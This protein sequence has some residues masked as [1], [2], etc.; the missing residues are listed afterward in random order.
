MARIDLWFLLLAT[1]CLVGGVSMGIGMGISQD[2]SLTPVHVH[3]NLVGWASL[4]L[5]GLTYR[6]WPEMRE[7][8]WAKAH[9][10][11]SA[12]ATVAFP[13]G[14]YLAISHQDPTLAIVSSLLWLCGVLIFLGKLIGLAL[15]P[16]AM[17]AE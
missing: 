11:I 5:F 8:V 1:V 7:G 17:P 14:I 16:P 15:A 4:A 2:F 10:V 3:V 13:G 12:P 6:A 9:F